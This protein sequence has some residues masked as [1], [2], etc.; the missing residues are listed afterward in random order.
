M[1]R[2]YLV[3]TEGGDLIGHSSDDA[4]Y[5]SRLKPGECIESDTRKA[6]NPGHH[7]KFFA[8]F[9][10]AFETQNKF[11]QTNAGKRALMI[12]LKLKAGW[13]DEHVTHDGRLVYVPRS[14]SWASMGQEKF[15]EL[16]RDAMIALAEI[17]SAE[18]VVMEADEII[19]RAS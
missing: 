18:E 8:L 4:A 13:Y 10:K 11:P 14:I 3:K 6:R 16:Y 1:T 9:N 15:D 17:S 5:L 19:A 12:E 7:K 2:L